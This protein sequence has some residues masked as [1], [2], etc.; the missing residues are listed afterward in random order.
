MAGELIEHM[1]GFHNNNAFV[2]DLIKI[3]ERQK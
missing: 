2:L 3:T 1:I